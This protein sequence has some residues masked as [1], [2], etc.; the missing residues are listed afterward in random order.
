[1]LYLIAN[2][3]LQVWKTKKNPSP[4][5]HWQKRSDYNVYLMITLKIVPYTLL[6]GKMYGPNDAQGYMIP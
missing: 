5:L 4:F 6:A 1:M 2:T 3:S